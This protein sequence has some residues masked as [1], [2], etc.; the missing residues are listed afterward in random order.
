MQ[1][2]ELLLFDRLEIIKTT[3]QKYD[4]ENN[5]YISFSGGKDSTVLHHLIDLAL[6]NNRIPRVFIN[7]GIEYVDIVKFVKEL[8]NNDDRF[9]ILQPSQSIK[10][11]LEEHGYPF[12]SKEHSQKVHEFNLYGLRPY[13]QRYVHGID[14]EGNRKESFTCNKLLKYQFTEDFKNNGFKISKKCCD[15]LKKE[16]AAKYEKENNRPIGI[17]GMRTSEGGTRAQLSCF[18]GKRFHPLS[19]VND[20]F[21]ERFIKKYQIILCKLYYPPY[22]FIRTGCKG[23]PYNLK[24]QQ[25][26]DTMERLLPNERKQCENIRKPVYEEYRK[27]NYRLKQKQQLSLFDYIGGDK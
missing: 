19:K 9:I 6:P 17:T 20:E 22:N 5:A 11:V 8:A 2:N 21:E 4:L 18:T 23:C 24:L 16:P 26:L 3:N 14:E 15:K 27:L 25:D 12:K 7:T 1:D 13:L 10:K